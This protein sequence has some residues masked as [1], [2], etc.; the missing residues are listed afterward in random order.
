[1]FVLF[2]LDTCPYCRKVIKFIEDNNIDYISKN[3]SDNL[4]MSELIKLGGKEQVP[5]LYDSDTNKGMYESD[6]IIKYLEF[7]GNNYEK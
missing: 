5:F 1:M 2:M 3:I 4:N 6:D 7:T